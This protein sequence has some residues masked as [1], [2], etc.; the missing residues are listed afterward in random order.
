MSSRISVFWGWAVLAVSGGCFPQPSSPLVSYAAAGEAILLLVSEHRRDKESFSVGRNV[1]TLGSCWWP[2]SS[3][4]LSGWRLVPTTV[5][6]MCAFHPVPWM[7]TKHLNCALFPEY[8]SCLLL[9]TNSTAF[10]HVLNFQTPSSNLSFLASLSAAERH[11]EI[12]SDPYPCA[13]L[14]LLKWN[15]NGHRLTSRFML[16]NWNSVFPD[17]CQGWA[18][19]SFI[20][21]VS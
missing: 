7:A 10:T 13:N 19:D 6:T 8:L 5:R 15:S 12:P 4:W 16:E 11:R 14:P 17:L 18:A 1:P 2:P 21:S 9:H 20:Q 3:L